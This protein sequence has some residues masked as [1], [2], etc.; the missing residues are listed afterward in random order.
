M[1]ARQTLRGSAIPKALLIVL[2]MCA[3]VLLA[4]GAS[5]ISRGAAGS[6]SSVTTNVHPAPGTILRQDNPVQGTQLI[7]RAAES[8]SSAPA[9]G[10][11]LRQDNPVQATS[12][13]F[14]SHKNFEQ[15]PGFRD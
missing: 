5:Y 14:R 9:P 2:A 4:V 8:T 15:M 13:A 7:D 11:V 12:G 10:T 1:E 3:A 6:G